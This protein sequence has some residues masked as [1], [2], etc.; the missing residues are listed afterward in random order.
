MPPISPTPPNPIPKR[1]VGVLAHLSSL[2]GNYGIGTL[3]KDAHH[4]IDFLHNCGFSYWQ[5]CPIGPTGYG[6][7]P[8][9]SFSSF[10]GNTYFI[11]LEELVTT[12]LLS[13]EDLLPLQSLSN[14][15]VD[16]G[17]LYILH[18]P[19]LLKAFKS[20]NTKTTL[21]SLKKELANFINNNNSWLHP[22]ASFRAFKDNFQQAPWWEWPTEYQTFDNAQ[23]TPLYQDLSQDIECYKFF[24]FLF[25]RQWHQLQEYAHQ[26][27]IE[28]IGDVPIFPPLDSADLWSNPTLFKL[29]KQGQPTHLAGVPPDYFSELGQFW[30][31]PL[32]NWE[33]KLAPC[34]EWWTTRIRHN[35]NLFDVLRLDHFRGFDSYWAIPAGSPDARTGEWIKGP[36]IK[37][38]KKI[39][40]EIPNARLIAEDLGIIT[41]SV[42]ELLK[43]TDLPGMA[44]LQFAFDAHPDNPFLPHNLIKKMTVYSGTHDNDTT[45]GWYDTLNE[46]YKDQVRRYFRVSGNNIAWDFIRA[47]YA[48]HCNLAIVTIQDLLNKNSEARLNTPSTH[49]GNWQWRFTSDELDNLQNISAPYLNELKWL[50]NR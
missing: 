28:L 40:Q 1:S 32:Y 4:F 15:K 5:M 17:S 44:I 21:S 8:Y 48:S 46:E 30:G 50:Y 6:D 2:P 20:F 31:N 14:T 39:N 3:G 7:S 38:F 23:K 33:K 9:Q 36:G 49:Q 22:Y 11:D 29:D 47:L 34:L 27:N 12:D 18:K 16:Y 37:L 10:A 19:L 13:Q 41:D 43:Q 24:Q 42:R 45:R 26:K 25:F 35:L